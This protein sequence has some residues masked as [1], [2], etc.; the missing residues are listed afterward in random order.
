G[1]EGFVWADFL[2]R[3]VRVLNDAH[4]ALLGEVWVGAARGVRNAFMLTLGTGVGG[5]IFADGRLLQG[6]IGRAGHLGHVSIDAAGSMDDFQTPGSL[7]QAMGNQT[8]Q[9]RSGGRFQT[10]H[11]LVDAAVAGEIKAFEWWSES[12]RG[13]AVAV[14]SL[15]NVLDPEV[16]VIGGGIA[17]G[18]GDVL[19]VPLRK[20]VAEFEWRPGGH[21]VK[22][23]LAQAG[24]WA[25]AVGAVWNLLHS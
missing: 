16:V 18:A 10:T 15:V 4:A 1:I 17:T 5:A 13:L 23:E 14:A 24:D 8:V 21:A 7:E 3:R 11:A 9:Q 22:L 20:A 19:M 6:H 2:E 25:G 12:L